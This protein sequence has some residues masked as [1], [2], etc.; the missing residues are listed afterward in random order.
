MKR[1]VAICG[2]LTLASPA[3]AQTVVDSDFSYVVTLPDGEEIGES[4]TA[5]PY[6]RGVCYYWHLRLAK[7]KGPISVS[8]IFTVPAEPAS[9]GV[10][11]DATIAV[12]DDKAAATSPLSLTPEDGWIG[13]GWCLAKGDPKGAHSIEI[14][15]GDTLLHRFDFTVDEL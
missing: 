14:L 6:V 1:L 9:W 2:L 8:E 10:G 7:T 4:S 3:L 5:V 15:A 12:F 13:H 11:E